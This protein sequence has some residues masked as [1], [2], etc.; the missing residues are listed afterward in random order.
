MQSRSSNGVLECLRESVGT[1]ASFVRAK[2]PNT[3]VSA[4]TTR[5]RTQPR[6]TH[7]AC[8]TRSHAR[9]LLAGRTSPLTLRRTLAGAA[10]PSPDLDP[11]G[12][13]P[14]AV[15]LAGPPRRSPGISVPDGALKIPARRRRIC[16]RICQSHRD[17]DLEGLD[18]KMCAVKKSIVVIWV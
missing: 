12:F 17:F 10:V 3:L 8:F 4:H 18:E 7:L 9:S 6:E 1:L 15:D 11:A 13:L 2:F 16:R 5:A 14:F